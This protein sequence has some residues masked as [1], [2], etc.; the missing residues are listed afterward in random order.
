MKLG[1]K[2]IQHDFQK[3]REYVGVGYLKID[4]PENIDYFP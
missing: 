2:F 1:K 3:F 4:N